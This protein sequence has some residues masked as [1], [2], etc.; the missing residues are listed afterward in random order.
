ACAAAVARITIV[1]EE[2]VLEHARMLGTEVIGPAL[3]ELQERHPS[4]GEVRGLGVF[5]AIELVRDRDTREPL[6]PFNATG[7]A[8]APMNEVM[9]ACK[10]R[11]M[12][13]FTHF[14]RIHVVPPCTI[15]AD[16]VRYGIGILDEVLELA[17]KHYVGS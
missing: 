3:R 9:T 15:S 2:G 6:V 13:P 17:D 1:K 10:A 11:G 12:W 4:V 7:E 14:N 8:A 5:W 16:D